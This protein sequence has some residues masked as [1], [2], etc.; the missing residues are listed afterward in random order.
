MGFRLKEVREKHGL[1]QEE[2]A[3]KSGISRVTISMIE[4]GKSSCVK[5]QTL[6]KLAD[7]LGEKASK[8]F[9]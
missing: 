9:F 6:L 7:A 1:T 5:T 3:R 8:L 4:S 2:L